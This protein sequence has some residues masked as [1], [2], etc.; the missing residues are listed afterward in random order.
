MPSRRAR[1][2]RATWAS[3]RERCASSR[4]RFIRSI[5]ARAWASFSLCQNWWVLSGKAM[6]IGQAMARR[7]DTWSGRPR[8]MVVRV[9]TSTTDASTDKAVATAALRRTRLLEK[10]MRQACLKILN[11][12]FR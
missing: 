5:A 6:R 10:D 1:S 8:R 9:A 2:A 3:A 7:M 11:I 4:S 12:L